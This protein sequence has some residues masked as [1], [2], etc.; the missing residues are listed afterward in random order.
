MFVVTVA[1]WIAML[2]VSVL[3]LSLSVVFVG[4]GA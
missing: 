3:S 2:T 1:S 4:F